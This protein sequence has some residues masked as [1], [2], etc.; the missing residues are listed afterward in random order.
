MFLKGEVKNKSAVLAL[1]LDK[2]MFIDNNRGCSLHE[3]PSWR[4]MKSAWRN[5]TARRLAFQA[6]TPEPCIS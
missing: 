6:D 5:N 4:L 2:Q 1:L 3:V